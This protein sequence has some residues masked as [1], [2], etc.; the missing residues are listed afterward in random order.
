VDDND[1]WTFTVDG[2]AAFKQTVDDVVI[3][4]Q[5]QVTSP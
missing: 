3:I 2:P 5:Y 1:K 4:C